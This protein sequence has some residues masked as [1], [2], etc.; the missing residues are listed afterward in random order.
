MCHFEYKKICGQRMFSF[1]I[2]LTF[3]SWS[4]WNSHSSLLSSCLGS[5]SPGLRA[6]QLTKQPSFSHLFIFSPRPF[7]I[8]APFKIQSWKEELFS[9]H[10]LLLQL[11]SAHS[12]RRAKHHFLPL[13]AKLSLSCYIFRSL[14]TKYFWCDWDIF[15]P[16]QC[17]SSVTRPDDSHCTLGS[18]AA[19]HIGDCHPLVTWNRS[20]NAPTQ[21]QRLQWPQCTMGE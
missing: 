1:Q 11:Y 12:L 16:A 13:S 8:K 15:V 3:Q 18:L 6:S 10:L 21:L 9:P 7:S 20:L 19:L 4:V 2:I 14:T 17:R 5:S